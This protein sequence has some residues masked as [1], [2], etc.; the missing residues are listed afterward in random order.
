[1]A[2]E[3]VTEAAEAEAEEAEA[4]LVGNDG[5]QMVMAEN[6]RKQW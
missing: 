4:E 5:K 1:M 3:V 2:V 6:R